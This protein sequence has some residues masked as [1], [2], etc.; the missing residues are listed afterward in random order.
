[1]RVFYQIEGQAVQIL[2]IVLKED[3]EEWLQTFGKR[4]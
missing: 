1:L 3:A 2:A 4:K